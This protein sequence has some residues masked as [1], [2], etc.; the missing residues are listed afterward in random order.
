MLLVSDTAIDSAL[1]LY[2]T[3]EEVNPRVAHRGR[4][5]KYRRAGRNRGTRGSLGESLMKVWSN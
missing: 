1:C 5:T 3:E 4:G 2:S